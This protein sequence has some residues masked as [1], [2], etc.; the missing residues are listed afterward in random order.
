MAYS[1]DDSLRREHRVGASLQPFQFNDTFS[2]DKFNH[3]IHWAINH[4]WHRSLNSQKDLVDVKR[5]D[6]NMRY[7]TRTVARNYEL[8]LPYY[9]YTLEIPFNAISFFDTREAKRRN[10]GKLNKT[11]C[12]SNCD[13]HHINSECVST[14]HVDR[15]KYPNLYTLQDTFQYRNMFNKHLLV[16][17]DG[18][19]FTDIMFFV[20]TDRLILVIEPDVTK[21][22]NT[23]V[24]ISELKSWIRNE[25]PV[26]IIGISWSPL[27][28]FDGDPTD[29]LS[30]GT[31]SLNKMKK[32]TDPMNVNSSEWILC[33]TNDDTN[34]GIMTTVFSELEYLEES[35]ET[36][37][38]LNDAITELFTRNAK[39]HCEAF[40]IANLFG[41]SGIEANKI[42]QIPISGN[43]IPTNNILVWKHNK[44]KSVELSTNTE[45]SIYYPN[46]YQIEPKFIVTPS[47]DFVD[48]KID[49][50]V[51]R[52]KIQD[53]SGIYLF[54]AHRNITYQNNTSA[55]ITVDADKFGN[56]CNYTAADFIF[57]F[58][59]KVEVK[60][61]SG[62]FE[63]KLNEKTFSNFVRNVTGKYEFVCINKTST[64]GIWMCGNNIV[65]LSDYGI[66]I[67]D[68]GFKVGDIITIWYENIWTVNDSPIDMNLCGISIDGTCKIGETIEVSYSKISWY[69]DNEAVEMTDWGID[70]CQSDILEN[71]YLQIEYLNGDPVG[72]KYD[73]AWLQSLEIATSFD[74]PIEDFMLYDGSYANN[75]ISGLLPQTLKDYI[76]LDIKYDYKD[77]IKNIKYTTA[78]SEFTYKAKRLAEVFKDNNKLYEYIYEQLMTRT[79][80][81]NHTNTK[82]VWD[83]SDIDSW[84]T[85]R[86]HVYGVSDTA[87]SIFAENLTRRLYV[88]NHDE[89]TKHHW[90]E[91]TEPCYKF[92]ISHDSPKSYAYSA[93]IDGLAVDIDYVYS[94]GF[95]TAIYLPASKIDND[96][97][98]E[99]EIMKIPNRQRYRT[100]LDFGELDNSVELPRIFPDVS[101]QNIM[102]SIRREV[103]TNKSSS[104]Y[105]PDLYD[106]LTKEGIEAGEDFGVKYYYEVAPAYEMYWLLFGRRKYV[107]GIAEGGTKIVATTVPK[108]EY[109]DT[110]TN[111][112]GCDLR[113]MFGEEFITANTDD[114]HNAVLVTASDEPTASGFYA[115]ERRRFYQYIPYGKNDEPIY[116]T[117]M[118]KPSHSKTQ[119]AVIGYTRDDDGKI[120]KWH[121]QQMSLHSFY[122]TVK[123]IAVPA[124]LANF[125]IV[126]D[127][128]ASKIS[129]VTGEYTFTYSAIEGWK[130]N[131]L[132]NI[133][134]ADY[135][136]SW[137]GGASDGATITI[138]YEALSYFANQ[139]VMIQN[140]DLYRKYTYTINVINTEGHNST[141]VTIPKFF[142]DPTGERFRVF[143]NGYLMEP[144]YDID[145]DLGSFNGNFI[146][147]DKINVVFKN[148]FKN[149]YSASPS[150]IISQ[151][152]DLGARI[153]DNTKLI[154][155]LDVRASG[156]TLTF[157]AHADYETD[158]NGKVTDVTYEWGVDVV[159]DNP[160]IQSYRIEHTRLDVWGIDTEIDPYKG[161]LSGS[162]PM[163]IVVS[164]PMSELY[165]DILIEYL[166]YKQ[167]RAFITNGLMDE[168]VDCGSNNLT[169]PLSLKYYD[170]YLDGVKL[171]EKDIKIISATKFLILGKKI[172]AS[173][174]S[175]YERAHDTE[176]Y[177]NEDKLPRSLIDSICDDDNDFTE[178]LV[179]KYSK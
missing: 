60:N 155:T 90:A 164:V 138:G 26:N 160:N 176:L 102:V 107:D 94:E 169:R 80:Y 142:D 45:V 139:H 162:D 61:V 56:A 30:S 150:V 93:W 44:D 168:L 8:G 158:D 4:L 101:P 174:V 172:R 137:D 124:E 95:K 97:I 104:A 106:Y 1:L 113:T 87:E 33:F 34:M 151:S 131:S 62:D 98:V 2:E 178:Y 76:P 171:Y 9:A 127:T 143:C 27:Y 128:F 63:Y 16:F 38:K 152:G 112:K 125:A 132:D 41:L 135:G 159:P 117:P 118:G 57:T 31:I 52:K 53:T 147:G 58:S 73:I 141:T 110:L 54:E 163:T 68:N 35:N 81:I 55:K 65:R 28:T 177:G 115:T 49:R 15:R 173:I 10:V 89:F 120:I 25:L 36:V 134:M 23:T 69:Y 111:Y 130:Y 12:T 145:M 83:F 22:D 148:G 92:V 116:L 42:F 165:A 179:K 74:N 109:T 86:P 175:I 79:A 114:T 37:F 51:F 156:Y 19:M 40:P 66:T 46:V 84:K 100:E 91:F 72:T 136:I 154:E 13:D 108:L 85:Y 21:N 20:D 3:D 78:Q 82:I 153:L 166:P 64:A 123:V 11:D 39:T 71:S 5:Y 47:H 77:H 43:A 144:H 146:R 119:E 122:G 126:S 157:K 170:I 99:F 32:I 103:S 18:K 67:S 133:N 121:T 149:P 48:F 75:V 14:H 7:F 167:N 6:T 105:N 161:T 50:E 88:D 29:I 24:K 70:V 59:P 96:S 140:T 129:Y 17:I